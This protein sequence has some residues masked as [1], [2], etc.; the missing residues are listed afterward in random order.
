MK[1]AITLF[2]AACVP[3][4]FGCRHAVSPR[5]N[6]EQNHHFPLNA[7][8]KMQREE[9]NPERK[10]GWM[11]TRW[12]RNGVEI[13]RQTDSNATGISACSIFPFGPCPEGPGSA[14]AIYF[15]DGR[16]ASVFSGPAMQGCGFSIDDFTK[17]GV[18]DLIQ[19]TSHG[20]EKVLEAYSVANGIVEPIPSSMFKPDRSEFYFDAPLI[21]YLKRKIEQPDAEVQSEGAPSD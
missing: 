17:D 12:F 7:L 21:R 15:L 5:V 2:V 6:S 13:L 16:M 14:L 1:R 4:A 3:L 18:P 20:H 19:I 8:V 11:Q 9:V 10:P